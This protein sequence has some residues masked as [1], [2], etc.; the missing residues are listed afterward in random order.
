MDPH[1]LCL[2]WRMS[3]VLDPHELYTY[4]LDAGH[5]VLEPEPND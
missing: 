5:L 4:V 1:E 2:G 3:Y